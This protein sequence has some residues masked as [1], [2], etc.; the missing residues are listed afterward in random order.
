MS[1]YGE[2]IVARPIN[3]V[4]DVLQNQQPVIKKQ[5]V[6]LGHVT[7]KYT[8]TTRFIDATS[9]ETAV[10]LRQVAIGLGFKARWSRFSFNGSL[11]AISP[12]VTRIHFE[13]N[14]NTGYLM[15]SIAAGMAFAIFVGIASQS[16]ICPA[17]ILIFMGVG[18]VITRYQTPHV[19]KAHINN[20]LNAVFQEEDSPFAEGA[21]KLKRKYGEF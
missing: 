3:D 2:F 7:A 19:Y 5:W 1:A 16:L 13:T 14:V 20:F 4:F 18:M 6:P 12:D 21:K 9:F 17:F 11:E 10:R 15:W 8:P